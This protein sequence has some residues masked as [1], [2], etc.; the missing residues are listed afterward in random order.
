[1]KAL[2]EETIE[3]IKEQ[4]TIK[5]L[6]EIGKEY[7]NQIKEFQHFFSNKTGDGKFLL[8]KTIDER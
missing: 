4:K 6:V 7:I 1:M 2:I 8:K 5:Q 3:H